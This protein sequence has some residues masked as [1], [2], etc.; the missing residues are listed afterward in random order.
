MRYPKE[1]LKAEHEQQG[2]GSTTTSFLDNNRQLLGSSGKFARK[3]NSC[4]MSS[5]PN[6]LERCYG[7]GNNTKEWHTSCK[8]P[9]TYLVNHQTLRPFGQTMPLESPHFMSLDRPTFAPF[10]VVDLTK[11]ISL[12]DSY[13]PVDSQR[14]AIKGPYQWL[15]QLQEQPSPLGFFL[16]FLSAS[17]LCRLCEGSIT[18]MLDLKCP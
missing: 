7:S 9:P 1:E 5:Q 14:N 16:C 6:F 17:I 15:L 18:L 13:V 10:F 8:R 4:H 12:A 11:D 3:P 2:L